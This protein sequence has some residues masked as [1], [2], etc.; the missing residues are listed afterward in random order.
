MD[1]YSFELGHT[2]TPS[3]PEVRSV[4]GDMARNGPAGIVLARPA[5]AQYLEMEF[6]GEVEE[7]EIRLSGRLIPLSKSLLVSPA[8]PVDIPMFRLPNGDGKC[9]LGMPGRSA[10]VDMTD[11]GTLRWE[12]DTQP[13]VRS[14]ISGAIRGDIQVKL[15]RSEAGHQMTIAFTWPKRPSELAF[16]LPRPAAGKVE[17]KVIKAAM[18]AKSLPRAVVNTDNGAT[19][20]IARGDS[21]IEGNC[22][23]V[24]QLG[25]EVI[26]PVFEGAEGKMKVEL[27]GPGWDGM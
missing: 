2:A 17:V 20:H 7:A 3:T 22:E 4:M 21:E 19:V 23:V 18:R 15:R 24:I 16:T 9:Q 8:I 25:A 27:V 26:L 5:P 6:E 13:I 12:D 10:I 14:P 1:E 11:P